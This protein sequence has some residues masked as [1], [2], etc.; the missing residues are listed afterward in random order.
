MLPGI[1]Q[2]STLAR[3][4]Q[5]AAPAPAAPPAAPAAPAGGVTPAAVGGQSGAGSF[6]HSTSMTNAQGG[7]ARAALG[8]EPVAASS[9]SGPN[10]GAMSDGLATV[11][12]IARTADKGRAGIRAA[13]GGL[14]AVE[15]G[16]AMSAGLRAADGVMGPLGVIAGGVGAYNGVRDMADGKIVEGG[17]DTVAGLATAAGGVGSTGTALMGAAAPAAL[18]VLAA[19][20][21]G[22]AAA[23][24]GVKDVY[25]GIRDGNVEQG[26]VG[27][28]KTAGGGMMMAGAATA[29]PLLIG[30]G[31][32]TYGG[33][34]IY[35][36]REAIG[37][38]ASAVGGAIMDGA[39]A[40]GGA[41]SSGASAVGGAVSDGVGAVG[42]AISGAWNWA[43]GN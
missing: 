29:N 12:S 3:T 1:Q 22:V 18:G 43:W 23:A 13:T 14:A 4:Q 8:E 9:G 7:A 24:D 31:A 41:I 20:G 25:Q 28:V 33:A 38:A 21:A 16:G 5:T 34:M 26:V 40:V 37:N 27:G 11:D 19:G 17:L 35:E 6:P 42:G 15:T 10:V 2:N 30:A 32:L 39:S 36:N